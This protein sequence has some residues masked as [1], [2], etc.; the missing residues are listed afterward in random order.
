MNE[1]S[2][3]VVARDHARQLLGALLALRRHARPSEVLL[4]DNASDAD[5]SGVARLSQLP[6]RHLR[7]PQHR[8]LGAAFNAGLE[9]AAHDYVLLL[10]DDA[11]LDSDPAVG[12]TFLA[13][14]PDVGIVGGKLLQD[15]PPPRLVLHAGYD[16]GVNRLV[17]ATVGWRRPDCYRD[18]ADVAAVSAACMTVRRSEIRFDERYWF[19]LEDVDLCYQYAQ[20]G[21]RVVFLPD[22]TAIHLVNGGAQERA[23]DPVWAARQLASQFLYHERWCSDCPLADHPRQD[24]VRGAAA[25]AYLQMVVAGEQTLV[26][27]APTR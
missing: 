1:Y 6:I 8:A 13:R 2:V 3:V 14:H 4:I 11:I 22:L 9:A 24:A 19:R 21:Y 15:G 17:P 26:A 23:A 16:V 25:L 5:L 20:R 12:V 27:T 18:V 7:L 10:H